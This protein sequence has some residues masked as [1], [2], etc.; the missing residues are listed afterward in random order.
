MNVRGLRRSVRR[1]MSISDS[2]GGASAPPCFWRAGL[3]R[4]GRLVCF[5]WDLWPGH[6]RGLNRASA[7]AIPSCGTGVRHRYPVSSML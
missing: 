2:L 6:V 3:C 5:G 7:S 4:A 1:M